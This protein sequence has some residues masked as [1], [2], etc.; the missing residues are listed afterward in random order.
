MKKCFALAVLALALSAADV[1][2]S[3][4][5]RNLFGRRSSCPS[6]QCS[7]AVSFPAA[8]VAAP[9]TAAKSDAKVITLPASCPD[10]RCPSPQV[11]RRGFGLGLFRR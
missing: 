5:I 3:G 10:G 6:G 2:A 1:S 7:P 8:P 9:P 4:P 11:E